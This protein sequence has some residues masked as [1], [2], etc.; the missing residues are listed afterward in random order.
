VPR[1]LVLHIRRSY[2]H[3]VDITDNRKLK[4]GKWCSFYPYVHVNIVL[5]PSYGFHVITWRLTLGHVTIN[6]SFPGSLCMRQ[7]LIHWTNIMLDSVHCHRILRSSG[8][9][10]CLIFVWP[11]WPAILIVVFMIFGGFSWHCRKSAPDYSTTAS[12]HIL[13]RSV[14]TDY[15]VDYW[16]HR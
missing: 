2:G 4:L 15:S 11:G 16:Q 8:W 12:F 1:S 7:W 6:L 9:H 13:S 5:K 10:C 14:F 3:C